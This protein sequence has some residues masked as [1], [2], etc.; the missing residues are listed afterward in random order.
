MM[1]I[2]L[3]TFFP[4]PNFGT[5]LQSY[6]LSK[7]L[8]DM[9]HEVEFI[10]NRH[11]VPDAE[12][13]NHTKQQIKEAIKFLLPTSIVKFIKARRKKVQNVTIDNNAEFAPDE[14]VY[15]DFTQFANS[16]VLLSI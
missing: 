5:C 3:V 14:S 12:G 15:S 6:A 1:K 9:G 13:V 2:K 8:S 4:H 16:E 7:V 11:E 10:Y